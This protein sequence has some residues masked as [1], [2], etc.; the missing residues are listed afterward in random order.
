V[1]HVCVSVSWTV[2]GVLCME[3]VVHIAACD[4]GALCLVCGVSCVV[5]GVSCV[6]CGVWCLV[7]GVSFVAR[8]HCAVSCIA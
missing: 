7:C 2:Y 5:C 3:Y 4:V 8:S 1:Y 6:V